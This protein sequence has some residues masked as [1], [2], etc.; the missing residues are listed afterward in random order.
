MYEEHIL[1]ITPSNMN[2]SLRWLT[3]L[4]EVKI[5][6]SRAKYNWTLDILQFFAT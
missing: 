3:L 5:G 4:M 1:A 2:P 6:K